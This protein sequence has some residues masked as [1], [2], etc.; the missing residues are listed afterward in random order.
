MS[1]LS[2]DF[3]LQGS[4]DSS[5]QAVERG[6]SQLGWSVKESEPPKRFVAGI[7]MTAFS[8]PGKVELLLDESAGATNVKMNG[9]IMGFGPVQKRHLRKSM[10]ELRDAIQSSTGAP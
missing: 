9:S 2:E 8:W 7:K 10:D 6:I 3:Q 5:S 1:K 4:V